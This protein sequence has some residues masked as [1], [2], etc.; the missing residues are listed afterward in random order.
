MIMSKSASP[1][2]TNP[3]NLPGWDL[4]DLY[5]GTDDPQIEKDLQSYRRLNKNLAA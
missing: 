2:K 3:D 4:G 1:L 5:K